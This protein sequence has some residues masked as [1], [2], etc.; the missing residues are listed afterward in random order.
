MA[1]SLRER[2]YSLSMS[3]ERRMTSTWHSCVPPRSSTLPVG[4]EQ[5]PSEGADM[6]KVVA[7]VGISSTEWLR[8]KSVPD[9]RAAHD[10]MPD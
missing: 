1:Y 3:T 4:L 5:R 7:S 2:F 8:S 10:P 6:E 9:S